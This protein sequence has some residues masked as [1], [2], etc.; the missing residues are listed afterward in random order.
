MRQFPLLLRFFWTVSP[1]PPLMP[2]ACVAVTLV[3]AVQIVL[4]PHRAAGALVPLLLLL[5]FAASSGFAVPAR[6]GHYD[7]ILAT[8]TSR[9][10]IAT[11][12]WLM[13]ILPG[14]G[15]WATLAGAELVMTR[16][17][18]ATTA[19]SGSLAALAVISTL[20]WALTVSLPRFAAA[21]GWLLA[22]ALVT[23][24]PY[25]RFLSQPL[26]NA[27]EGWWMETAIATLLYPPLL[28]GESVAGAHSLVVL[29]VLLVSVGAMAYAFAWVDRQ[30]IPL[31]TAQ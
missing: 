20:P 21:I 18:A 25:G 28:L 11:A 15:G 2:A 5:L 19:S 6:R 7:F 22:L 9:V 27:G 17:G 14:L 30:D 4:D 31:E 12:H 8:G 13:S 23:G 10:W 26:E 29:P 1:L 24:N 16:G 3:G